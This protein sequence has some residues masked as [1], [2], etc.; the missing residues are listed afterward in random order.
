MSLEERVDKARK[1]T[2]VNIPNA[3]TTIVGTWGSKDDFYRVELTQPLKPYQ[4]TKFLNGRYIT[5]DNI[6]VECVQNHSIYNEKNCNCPG[7]SER[8]VC[9]HSMGAL[10]FILDQRGQEIEFCKDEFVARG[11]VEH[12]EWDRN[13]NNYHFAMI[14]SKTGHKPSMW[15]VIRDKMPVLDHGDMAERV[16]SIRGSEAEEEGID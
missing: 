9:Y 3:P 4:I 11:A 16:N 14:Q 7:N 8:T 10:M 6:I 13:V 12:S 15:A 1:L 5:L 2:L